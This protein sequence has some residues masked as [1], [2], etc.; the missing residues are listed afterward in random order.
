MSME[1]L[2][3]WSY[4]M[5]ML[6]RLYYRELRQINTYTILDVFGCLTMHLALFGDRESLL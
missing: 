5:T 6:C 4:L 3:V 1:A 2:S